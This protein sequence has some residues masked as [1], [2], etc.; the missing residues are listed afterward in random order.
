MATLVD[1]KYESD[2]GLIYPLRMSAEKDALSIAP[3]GVVTQNVRAKISKSNR[4]FGI[5]PRQATLSRIQGTAP[6]DFRVYTTV[7]VKTIGQ[8]NGTDFSIGAV[9]T[10]G[11][12]DWTVI[13]RKG[14][15]F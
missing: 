11:T 8:W 5:G 2:A 10:I 15:D 1:T 3:A 7:V 9:V 4:E 6:N 13:S 12:T 14:E